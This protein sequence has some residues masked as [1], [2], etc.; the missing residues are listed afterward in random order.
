M[1]WERLAETVP[2]DRPVLIAGPTA[3]GKS[4]LAMAIAETGGGRIVNADALQVF[5][6][7]QILTARPSPEDEA[8]VS[9]A[10][11]GHVPGAEA[12]SVGR[13]LRDVAPLLSGPRPI[14]VG[15]TGLYFSALTAGLAEIPPV[16]RDVSEAAGARR[17]DAGLEAMISDLD[18]ESAAR[19]DLR[20][21]RRVQRAWEVLK[22][23]GRGIAAWQD[24]TGPPL[25]PLAEAV[26]LVL[27]APPDWLNPRI[28]ARFEAM[29]AAGLL[30]EAEANRA[31]W[32]PGLPSAKAIGA[33]EVMAHLAGAIDLSQLRN[34]V[35]IQTRQYAK[36]QRSWFRGRMG[37]WRW[38]DPDPG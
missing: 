10:L 2:P 24:D 8:R 17:A 5:S 1:G 6:D 35:A 26:P 28:V 33:S 32:H 36:R 23:T 29:L 15:G 37:D 19:I 22:A 34:N 18:E 11:Y 25:L 27:R 21:P 9:H 3:S 38:I 30:A 20:N 16:P 14:V 13:W 7:W 31:A 12:Y 4:A